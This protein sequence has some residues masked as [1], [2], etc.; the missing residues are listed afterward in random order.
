MPMQEM[1]SE[2]RAFAEIGNM[3]M[4][5]S[6]VLLSTVEGELVIGPVDAKEADW[7]YPV[8]FGEEAD[9]QDGM[10]TDMQDGT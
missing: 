1:T 9:L 7:L 6:I 2:L 5:D 10:E 8:S 4:E 3:I